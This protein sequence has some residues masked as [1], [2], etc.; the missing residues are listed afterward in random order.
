VQEPPVQSLPSLYPEGDSIK[1][2]RF[3]SDNGTKFV[4]TEK[5]DSKLSIS[6]LDHESQKIVSN[7]HNALF[8]NNIGDNKSEWGD[9]LKMKAALEY[10]KKTLDLVRRIEDT[11]T[12][13]NFVDVPKV[14]ALPKPA[15]PSNVPWQE[16]TD[17]V[18]SPARLRERAAKFPPDSVNCYDCIII[19]KLDA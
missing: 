13:A 5:V 19:V 11:A 16:S 3:R 15:S 12:P 6:T 17:E 8:A 1:L 4:S 18:I 14:G 2:A 10:S 7:F 9:D